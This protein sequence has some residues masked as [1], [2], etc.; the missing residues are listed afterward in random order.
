MH[1]SIC[2][3]LYSAI[4]TGGGGFIGS[5]LAE[6][7]VNHGVETYSVDDTTFFY[8]SWQRTSKATTEL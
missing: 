5:H 2:P 6:Y 7:I 1:I 8:K 3:N 4:V